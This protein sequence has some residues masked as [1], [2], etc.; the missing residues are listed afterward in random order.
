MKTQ[1]V[2]KVGEVVKTAHQAS[3]KLAMPAAP[4]AL[5]AQVKL[6]AK[7]HEKVTGKKSWVTEYST[8][9][10]II[11]GIIW[12]FGKILDF[13]FPDR[14]WTVWVKIVD[15]YIPMVLVTCAIL[16]RVYPYINMVFPHQK[17]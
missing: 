8:A 7:T 11:L 13:H 14:S 2:R 9:I 15:A 1:Q 4:V 5:G 12:S 16:Y 10:T 17:K 3:E 6:I